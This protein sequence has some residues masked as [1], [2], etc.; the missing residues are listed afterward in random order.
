M[1]A[2]GLL[3]SSKAFFT[4]SPAEAILC[5]CFDIHHEK[6]NKSQHPPSVQNVTKT[7]PSLNKSNKLAKNK[8]FH[9]VYK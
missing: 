5:R 6:A 8:I 9:S 4:V 7:T 2:F 1:K 3:S